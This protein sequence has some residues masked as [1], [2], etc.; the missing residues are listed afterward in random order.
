MNYW[1]P[2]INAYIRW[3]RLKKKPS[4]QEFLDL[5]KMDRNRVNM[6]RRLIAGDRLRDS[7]VLL[8]PQRHWETQGF[9]MFTKPDI[10]VRMDESLWAIKLF[11]SKDKEDAREFGP[12][13]ADLLRLSY[14]GTP[15]QDARVV[16]VDVMNGVL[17]APRNN[18]KVANAQVT[19]QIALLRALWNALSGEEAA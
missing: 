10:L 14:T 1:Q 3:L 16:V 6:L 11:I 9:K 2:S 19:G 8:N 12:V 17:Y 7:V 13:A 15:L 4:I 18:A 5:Q